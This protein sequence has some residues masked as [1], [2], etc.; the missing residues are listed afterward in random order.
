MKLNLYFLLV[1]SILAF[2]C[3]EDRCE[4]KKVGEQ[5]LDEE[6]KKF[7]PYADEEVLNFTATAGE[8]LTF[9]VERQES[10]TDRMCVKYLCE[11]FSDPFQQ[12]PCEYYQGES[13]RNILRGNNDTLLIDILVSINNYEEESLLF[14]D[15]LMLN[16]SGIGTFARG[17]G[18][19]HPHF[20]SPQIIPENLN[21][22]E[23]LVFSE[24]LEIDGQT[25]TNV[26]QS[27]E[28]NHVVY[29]QKDT[30]I[31]ALKFNDKI[32]FKEG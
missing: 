16:F 10:F 27:T 24:N 9:R 14:Y 8:S 28:G 30:G 12:I 5:R 11:T 15:M 13:I 18:V 20:D 7:A 23:P 19:L 4:S 25:F 32:Y 22:S 1:L 29:Y 31:I 17:E 26:F 3:K 6:S 2:G 21:F